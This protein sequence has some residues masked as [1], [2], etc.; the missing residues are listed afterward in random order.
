MYAE[1]HFMNKIALNIYRV[2][3]YIRYGLRLDPIYKFEV[4]ID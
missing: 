4:I 2:Y 1:L 3:I